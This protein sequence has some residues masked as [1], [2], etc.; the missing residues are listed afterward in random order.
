MVQKNCVN[1]KLIIICGPTA[2]GKTSLSVRV[3]KLLNSEIVSADSMNV[4]RCLN[5]GTAKPTAKEM[6]EIK[7][8]LIDVVSP[9]NSFSV[10]D[11]R[12]LAL[13]IVKN[14]QNN[15]KIPI[16]CGGTGFYIN[17]LIYD[18]SYGNTSANLSARKKYFDLANEYG[19]EYVYNILK[20]V[21]EK[22]S[23]KI[24]CNDLKRVIRAL[25]IYESGTVKSEII[26]SKIPTMDYKAYSIDFKREELYDRIDKRVDDMIKNGLID[27]V[28]SLLS[29]GIKKTFQCMQGIGYKEVVE[30]LENVISLDECIYKIKLNTHHY[31]KRQI[32]FFK[33]LPNI[34]YLKPDDVE[35]LAKRII[36]DYD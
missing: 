8:H 36:N 34:T 28:K 13:P 31:A 20:M 32:T 16:V 17:S 5:I 2:S 25:E 10:G 22:S 30:Y 14:I 7:H 23:S 18:F 1:N 35:V 6:G 4:Y 27:E 19:N 33:K 26:D 29:S 3:A 21:D 24:H 9:F 11:Y 15:N 12:D